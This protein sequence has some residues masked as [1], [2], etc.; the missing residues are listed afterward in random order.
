MTYAISKG[1]I[2][3]YTWLGK[4]EGYKALEQ[5]VIFKDL[6]CGCGNCEAVC[7]ENV[8]KVSE[9]P[10]LIG[11]CTN[12]GYC[13]M[14]CPRSF[15]SSEEAEEK[16]FGEITE[17]ELGHIESKIGVRVKDEEIKKVV[18]DGGFVTAALKYLLEK[19]IIDGAVVS[20]K[21]EDNPWSPMAK[22]VVSPRELLESAGTRYTNSPN[23]AA[24]KEAKEKG[25]KN[26][27]IVGL[28]CQIEAVR[29]IQNYPIEDVDISDRIKLTISIFCSSN[30]MYDGLMNK[31]VQEK[32]R[33]PLK[34]IKKMDIKGKN[35]LV[36]TE[37]EEV[38]IPL[39]EAYTVKREPCKVCSDFTG[40]LADISAGAVGSPVGYTTVFARTKFA[41]KLLDDMLNFGIFETIEL[42]EEKPGLGIARKLQ[43]KKE[44]EASEYVR[45]RIK[46]VLPLPFK[47][48]KF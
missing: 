8:I 45:K 33:V 3:E 9:F 14:Q 1:E 5:E 20:A 43:M 25:L 34:D 47:G 10:E 11:K 15:F 16:L 42:E 2:I 12:C 32:Y 48:L 27:A 38:K 17:D 29:K 41:V 35:V 40:R 6:C 26:L 30:F 23:T 18:Q 13:L 22:L 31:L 28:P 46:E 4:E 44:K 36:F 21:G 24:L 19:N 37:K 7:P 39:K